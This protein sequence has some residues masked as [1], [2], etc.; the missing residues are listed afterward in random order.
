M[1]IFDLVHK[2]NKDSSQTR[3]RPIKVGLGVFL[4]LLQ[5][6]C[7]GFKGIS[8]HSPELLGMEAVSLYSSSEP[9]PFFEESEFKNLPE[10]KSAVATIPAGSIQSLT[11]DRITTFNK[12]NSPWP[13]MATTR[14]SSYAAALNLVRKNGID[15]PLLISVSQ[16]QGYLKFYDDLWYAALEIALDKNIPDMQKGRRELADQVLQ[17]FRDQN[18]VDP[19]IERVFANQKEILEYSENSILNY[20]KKDPFQFKPLSFYQGLDLEKIWIS[21]RN[22]LA[23]NQAVFNQDDIRSFDN[24]YQSESA[25]AQMLRSL[26]RVFAKVTNRADPALFNDHGVVELINDIRRRYAGPQKSLWP[27]S[28][29]GILDRLS[30]SERAEYDLQGVAQPS[31]NRIVEMIKAR[32]VSFQPKTALRRKLSCRRTGCIASRINDFLMSF[33]DF[34]RG[35]LVNHFP[36]ASDIRTWSDYFSFGEV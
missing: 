3:R 27:S 12:P 8:P 1:S 18:R 35:G 2:P 26:R 17:D 16:I 7:G 4:I 11:Y 33:L 6:G 36:K 34:C 32:K 9:T 28:S 30:A 22:L 13:S 25:G 29:P 20:W 23:D 5:T 21:D 14:S 24:Y 15:F 31:M 10:K 19:T